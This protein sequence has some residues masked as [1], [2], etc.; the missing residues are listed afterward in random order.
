MV[1]PSAQSDATVDIPSGLSKADFFKYLVR[2]KITGTRGEGVRK[3]DLIR[4]NLFE[5][6]Y[7]WIKKANMLKMSTSAAMVN[8]TYMAGY[9]AYSLT[10]TLPARMYYYSS[11]TS[12]NS[13]IGGLYFNSLYKAAPSSTPQALPVPPGFISHQH[14]LCIKFATGYVTGKGELLPIP[15]PVRDA[16]PNMSQNPNYW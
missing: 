9:P 8:P 4:W 16:N 2:G 11:T 13:N 1:N 7:Q 15:Q 10:T 6:C 3:Y 12:D 14:N 5:R